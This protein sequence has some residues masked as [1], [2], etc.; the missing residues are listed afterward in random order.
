MLVH[1]ATLR[2]VDVSAR[3]PYIWL[4]HIG[5][6][7]DYGVLILFIRKQPVGRRALDNLPRWTIV[8]CGALLGYVVVNSIQSLRFTGGANPAVAGGHYVLT[9][10]GR[11]L[12][13]L[14]A[15]QY[16]TYRAYE[17]RLFSGIWLIFF[18]LPS[19]YFAVSPPAN[20]PAPPAARVAPP[21]DSGNNTPPQ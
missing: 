4:L 14:T 13:Q 7:L 15:Q 2:G 6:I 3:V 9:M 5:A 21:A 8:V 19:L 11:M 12:G 17:L 16:R 1:V 10:H 20:T 18:L